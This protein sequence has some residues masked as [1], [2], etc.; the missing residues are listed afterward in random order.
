MSM[1]YG[2]SNKANLAGHLGGDPEKKVLLNRLMEKVRQ[3]PSCW[4]WT[5]ALSRGYGLLARGWKKSPYKAHRL[6]YELLI[7]EVPLGAVVRHKCDNPRCVNPEHLE[8]GTQRDN[9]RDAAARGR[10][11]PIS[12]RNLRPGALGIRGAGPK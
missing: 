12:R 6:A 2:R 4:N 8:L 11:N 5:G 3:G 7:G 9:L 1:V 10:L